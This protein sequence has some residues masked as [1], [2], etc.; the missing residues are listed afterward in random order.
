MAE[1]VSA[2]SSSASD[3]G[4]LFSTYASELGLSAE[5]CGSSGPTAKLGR[6]AGDAACVERI[7]QFAQA[8]AELDISRNCDASFCPAASGVRCWGLF[9]NATKCPRFP[10]SEEGMPAWPGFFATGRSFQIYVAYLA[11]A[12]ILLGLST[13]G[14]RLAQCGDTF[15][16][17]VPA[18]TNGQ[19]AQLLLT[20]CWGDYPALIALISCAFLLRAF[21]PRG[22]SWE[23]A[24]LHRAAWNEKRPS[25]LQAESSSSS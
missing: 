16:F 2:D 8:G 14:P 11:Q 23:W 12:C 21:S 6:V 1:A 17:P 3:F 22:R 4:K 7:S 24:H 13:A 15:S 19:P 20:E 5:E 25:D 10:L 9:C 18:I